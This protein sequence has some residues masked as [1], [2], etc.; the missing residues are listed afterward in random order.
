M[1]EVKKEPVS[2]SCR[3][4]QKAEREKIRR[5]KLNEQFLELGNALDPNRPKS[6]KTLILNDTIQTL[7]DLMTQVDRLK[8]EYVT[9]SQ[10]S[11]EQLMQEKSELRVEK[12][13]LKSD[14]ECLNAQYQD[15]VR[16]TMVPWIPHYAYPLPVV[17]IT[18]AP[19]AIPPQLQPFPFYGNL[20]EQAS[21]QLSSSSSGA[22]NKQDSKSKSLDLNMMRNCYQTGHYKDDVGLELELKLHA[23]SSS[24]TQQDASGQEKKRGSS[25][26]IASSSSEAVQ[27]SSSGNINHISKS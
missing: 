3:K 1:V 5:D 24:S 9:L 13:S 23:S 7:K 27:D 21:I 11:R 8:A 6:D 4:I 18:Q 19:V 16:K 26:T 12:S 25:T 22:S 17:A 14:I 10:E 15:R 20:T 2:A